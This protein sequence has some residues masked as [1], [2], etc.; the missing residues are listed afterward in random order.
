MNKIINT[1]I[2]TLFLFAMTSAMASCR[3]SA[4]ATETSDVTVTETVVET[5]TE[6]EM[7]T[8]TETEAKTEPEPTDKAETAQVTTPEETKK[9][10]Q[11]PQATTPLPAPPQTQA[12]TQP[13]TQ[14]STPTAP[15]PASTSGAPAETPAAYTSAPAGYFNDALFVGDS[16]TVGLKL[17]GS[18]KEADYFASEGLN[19]YSLPRAT[20]DINGVGKVNLD[21]LLASKQYTKIYVMFGINE[22]GYGRVQTIKKYGE[23]INKLKQAQPNAIIFIE[24]N[25]YVSENMS[26][27]HGVITNHQIDSFNRDISAFA[28][29]VRS[30]YID[31]NTIFN[32]GRGNLAAEYASDGCHLYPKYHVTW[33]SWL[34][35][36][37]IV[38]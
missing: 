2:L 30:F 13:T 11:A 38:K 15:P 3:E 29:G 24:A 33:S 35:S 10:T 1:V 18:I 16:R 6:T 19:I 8:E 21:T 27:T 5:Q 34:A 9:E 25:I 17:Y 23:L 26:N 14:P 22:L 20:V 36:K 31:V 32:D 4:A 37:A 28:D 12:P 7:K